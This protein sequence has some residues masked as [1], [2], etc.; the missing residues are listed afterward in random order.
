MLNPKG[1]RVIHVIAGLYPEHGGLSYTVPRLCAALAE[2]GVD[3]ALFSVTPQ[4]E[5]AP[6][7]TTAA[8]RGTMRACRG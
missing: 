3:V 5:I 4:G 2:P 6:D 7:A 8:S 1:I